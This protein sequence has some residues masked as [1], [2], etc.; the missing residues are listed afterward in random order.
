MM[1]DHPWPPHTCTSLPTYSGQTSQKPPHHPQS[2]TYHRHTSSAGCC[3][4][5]HTQPA[6]KG[7]LSGVT[8]LLKKLIACACDD[9]TPAGY[10]QLSS[11][12]H[13]DIY[14]VGTPHTSSCY[15]VTAANTPAGPLPPSLRLCVLPSVPPT[16]PPSFPPAMIQLFL[17]PS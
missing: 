2:H 10:E 4:S 3:L 1:F 8:D 16:L 11:V 7:C 15:H 6:S 13:P 5:L 14:G 17:L 12:P 9:A